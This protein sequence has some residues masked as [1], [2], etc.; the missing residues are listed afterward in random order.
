MDLYVCRACLIYF[1]LSWDS[2][3]SQLVHSQCIKI[4][5]STVI[6]S[7]VG[8]TCSPPL[9]EIYLI[10]SV[11]QKLAYT[12]SI[13]VT[14]GPVWTAIKVYV[15]IVT[16]SHIKAGEK[17][18]PETYMYTSLNTV[19]ILLWWIDIYHIHL[20]KHEFIICYAFCLIY[21]YDLKWADHK[22]N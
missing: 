10:Y 14:L 4:V 16:T 1:I 12:F 21:F 9:S 7:F 13:H 8:L 6:V 20:G 11:C 18:T 15:V 3:V 19:A 17:P 5:N 2:H 22:N